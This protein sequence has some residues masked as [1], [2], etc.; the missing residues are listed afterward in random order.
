ME[1]EGGGCRSHGRETD[2]WSRTCVSGRLL[3]VWGMEE[4]ATMAHLREQHHRVVPYE[5][6]GVGDCQG[7]GREV[8]IEE[9][10]HDQRIVPN[11]RLPVGAELAH[12][13]GQQLV[14]QRGRA[15]A[16]LAERHKSG[17]AQRRLALAVGEVGGGG[18][19]LRCSR[20]D[21]RRRQRQRERDL[22]VDDER[23][24]HIARAGSEA[25]PPAGDADGASARGAERLAPAV[26]RSEL[27]QGATR[28]RNRGHRLRRSIHRLHLVEELLAEPGRGLGREPA[29]AR[30]AQNDPQG[31][32]GVGRVRCAAACGGPPAV[33]QPDR[34]DQLLAARLGRAARAA[35]PSPRAAAS[36]ASTA[37]TAGASLAGRRERAARAPMA[38]CTFG[39][40]GGRIAAKSIHNESA[41][42]WC[43][44]V[45]HSESGS[46]SI[47]SRASTAAS[48]TVA[49]LSRA[50]GRTPS[51]QAARMAAELGSRRSSAVSE[52]AACLRMEGE[53]SWQR[54]AMAAIW[55]RDRPMPVDTPHASSARRATRRTAGRSSAHRCCSRA[56]RPL[57]LASSLAAL[58]SE[59]DG[60]APPSAG[61][62]G[63]AH[64]PGS[65][66]DA[67]PGVGSVKERSDSRRSVPS[68]G[69]GWWGVA[70]ERGE[71]A[72]R[73]SGCCT[74]CSTAAAAGAWSASSSAARHPSAFVR[75]PAALSLT[76]CSTS[77]QQV[78]G[79][80]SAASST[81]CASA[82]LAASCST[83]ALISIANV[84]AP[85][86]P[87]C[88]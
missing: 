51:I 70:P 33:E 25:R 22:A 79:A 6:R 59:A 65:F 83:A 53:E 32:G 81:A 35:L 30:Q 78:C 88:P 61:V 18:N 3:G 63:E 43:G 28:L 8:P 40:D 87:V 19:H 26:V 58:T 38:C 48:L 73:R 21:C 31:A 11:C 10:E 55:L 36:C 85:I 15:E 71:T 68:C 64:E 5:G 16:E 1:G 4:D 50:R 37:W 66:L 12:E 14:G 75:A 29:A 74:M 46:T 20:A 17:R 56:P 47:S 54:S 57:R 49:S 69:V 9:C 60:E 2:G 62:A 7:D 24:L 67:G 72:D 44:A 23:E 52:R 13:H 77:R 80:S 84:R 39:R 76:R 27:A 82:E 45:A 42:G 41:G 86:L 34:L